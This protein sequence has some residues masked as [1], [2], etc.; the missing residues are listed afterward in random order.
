MR[1][2]ELIPSKGALAVWRR[3]LLVWRQLFWP[4]MASNVFEP[5][6]FLFAFGFGLGAIVGE[7][8]ELPYLVFIVPGVMAYTAMFAASF[9]STISAYARFQM[10]RTWDAQLATPLS[11]TDVLTGELLWATTK[12]MIASSC[13]LVV[14]WLWGGIPSLAGAVL[15][16]PMLALAALC[17]GA[18]G[19]CATA[20]AKNWDF[21]NYFFTFWVTPMFIFSGVFFEVSRFPDA[22][23]WLAWVL[24]MTHLVAVLRPLTVGAGL[25]VLP[26]IGHLLYLAAMAVTAFTAARWR[27]GERMFD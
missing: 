21:Y 11:L 22:V 6:L 23:Q 25:D 15:G 8:G 2:E 20:F 24:P 16:L 26:T 5:L 13:V 7:L 17:Y 12:A 4:S 27:A 18:V 14:G 9:E 10:Q 1:I 3:H 19:L